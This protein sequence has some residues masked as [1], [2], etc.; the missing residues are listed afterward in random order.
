[1]EAWGKGYPEGRK[2]ELEPPKWGLGSSP[3]KS[4]TTG[5]PILL[6]RETSLFPA[7]LIYFEEQEHFSIFEGLLSQQ[8][9]ASIIL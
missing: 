5:S 2:T 1:M 7:W 9:L 6:N 8:Q 4:S 3:C